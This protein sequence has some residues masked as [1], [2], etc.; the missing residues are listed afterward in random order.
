MTLGILERVV[1]L[2]LMGSGEQGRVVDVG[3]SLEMV[4]RLAELGI[5]EGSDLRM[6]RPGQPC[7]I[8]VGDQRLS[9]RGETA[10]VVLVETNGYA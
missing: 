3:G 6:V 1:P 8:A 5:R 9:F 4:G 2:D 10:A 7:I